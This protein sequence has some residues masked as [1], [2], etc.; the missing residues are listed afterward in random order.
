MGAAC[1]MLFIMSVKD[2]TYC[3]NWALYFY[4][5]FYVKFP[6]TI[7]GQG[8]ILLRS[9]TLILCCIYYVELVTFFEWGRGEWF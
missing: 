5:D 1:I 3:F 6:I 9:Y 7:G 8:F 4:L 2:K